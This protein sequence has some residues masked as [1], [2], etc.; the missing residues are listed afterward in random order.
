[1]P[2]E[3]RRNPQQAI[4]RHKLENTL[5]N[6][7][8][9]KEDVIPGLDRDGNILFISKAIVGYDVQDILGRDFCDWAPESDHAGMRA[10]MAVGRGG[11]EV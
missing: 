5:Q 8:R 11:V 4:G 6:I 1:M 9:S 3:E 10:A 2:M 7:L